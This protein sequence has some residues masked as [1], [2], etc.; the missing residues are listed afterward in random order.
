MNWYYTY[1]KSVGPV[2]GTRYKG[3][4]DERWSGAMSYEFNYRVAGW[5]VK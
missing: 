2:D 1:G 5:T 4:F 3:V